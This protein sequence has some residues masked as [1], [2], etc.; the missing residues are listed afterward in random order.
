VARALKQ[1]RVGAIFTLCGGHTSDIY[2]GCIDEGIAI[3]DVRHEQ[4][5]AR[6]ELVGIEGRVLTL[7][8]T[9]ADARGAIGEGAHQRAIIDTERFLAR[10][11]EV[12][13]IEARRRRSY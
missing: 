4:T 1:E 9:V 8:I 6:A 3:V 13:F 11:G 7:R 2:D 12:G 5:A 10:P